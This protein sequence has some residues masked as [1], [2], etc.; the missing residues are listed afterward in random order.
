M[1]NKTVEFNRFSWICPFEHQ[2]KHHPRIVCV[3]VC[4]SIVPTSF[5]S[6]FKTETD[7][8]HHHW[9]NIDT[10]SGCVHCGE[11]ILHTLKLEDGFR[12]LGDEAQITADCTQQCWLGILFETC[13]INFYRCK[14]Q[15][16]MRNFD[17]ISNLAQKWKSRQ[18]TI[19]NHCVRSTCLFIDQPE[20]HMKLIITRWYKL[21]A[22]NR[23]L[24]RSAKASQ[25]QVPETSGCWCENNRAIKR[26]LEEEEE[27]KTN[28]F[29]SKRRRT[30]TKT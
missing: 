29:N 16:S 17:C 28:I 26:V 2:S 13:E 11:P 5:L 1:A 8:N 25:A 6:F 15:F 19:F 24:N 23:T 27:E 9:K 22:V 12:N 20:F 10:L 14:Y 7:Q 21:E 4:R 18:Q 30:A 3:G